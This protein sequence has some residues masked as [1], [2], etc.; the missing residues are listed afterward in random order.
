LG[1]FSLLKHL[2]LFTIFY[3]YDWRN[4]EISS[5]ISLIWKSHE[6]WK[7][8]AVYTNRV[9]SLTKGDKKV[10]RI[11]KLKETVSFSQTRRVL[12]L[13]QN[14]AKVYSCMHYLNDTNKFDVSSKSHSFRIT[15]TK[16]E[17]VSRT[18]AACWWTHIVVRKRVYVDWKWMNWKFIWNENRQK[19]CTK[20]LKYKVAQDIIRK[21]L[22]IKDEWRWSHPVLWIDAKRSC[23]IWMYCFLIY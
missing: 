11:S 9:T 13:V 19:K 6:E 17:I 7:P 4:C 1:K 20:K 16:R 3:W 10:V 22:V 5:P 18:F 12:E 14:E 15:V 2:N 21:M 8:D 23:L